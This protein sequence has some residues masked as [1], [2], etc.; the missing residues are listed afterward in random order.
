[1]AAALRPIV[2]HL[3]FRRLA[4]LGH[5]RYQQC[6]QPSH[7]TLDQWPRQVAIDD[8]RLQI[9]QGGDGQ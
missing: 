7:Q 4:R 6:P 8:D 2:L 1:M 3:Q 9:E 5:V